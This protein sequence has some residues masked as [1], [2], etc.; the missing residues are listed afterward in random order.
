MDGLL[1]VLK[2]AVYTQSSLLERLYPSMQCP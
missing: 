1:H 2:C